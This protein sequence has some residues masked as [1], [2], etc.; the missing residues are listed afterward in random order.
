MSAANMF[1]RCCFFLALPET[2]LRGWEQYAHGFGAVSDQCAKFDATPLSAEVTQAMPPSVCCPGTDSENEWFLEWDKWTMVHRWIEDY[3]LLE[4]MSFYVF[5]VT[6]H[7]VMLSQ[8]PCWSLVSAC[9]P[10]DSGLVKL[11]AACVAMPCRDWWFF[12][13]P[14]FSQYM[15]GLGPHLWVR[16][17]AL[18]AA[19]HVPRVALSSLCRFESDLVNLVYSAKVDYGSQLAKDTSIR[20]SGLLG[21]IFVEGKQAAKSSEGKFLLRFCH[22]YPSQV[23]LGIRG[24]QVAAAS[25]L[26]AFDGIFWHVVCRQPQSAAAFE[27][28]ERWMSFIVAL[29][30][31]FLFLEGMIEFMRALVEVWQHAAAAFQALNRFFTLV[32]DYCGELK[33]VKEAQRP[34]YASQAEATPRVD[35]GEVSQAPGENAARSFKDKNSCTK[36]R[37]N[38]ECFFVIDLSGKTLTMTSSLDSYVS[39][40]VRDVSSVT[41]IPVEKFYLVVEG[42]VL[43]LDLTLHQA[44]I[45]RDVSVRMCFRL[46][47][48]VRHEVPGSWTC[49]VCNMGG[50]WPVRQNCFRCGAVR[51]SGP[52][53]PSGREMRYPGRG[54][55]GRASNGNPTSRQPRPKPHPVGQQPSS[56]LNTPQHSSL[57]LDASTLLQVLQSLGLGQDL[58]TQVEAKLSPPPKKERGPEKRLTTLKGKIHMCQQQLVKLRKQC[59]NT[60][61]TFLELEQKFIAKEK[62]QHEYSQEYTEILRNKKLTPTP[63]EKGAED[64]LVE[65]LQEDADEELT[66]VDESK[67]TVEKGSPPP[68]P[69]LTQG[70][71]ALGLERTKAITAGEQ[72]QFLEVRRLGSSRFSPYEAKRLRLWKNRERWV[73]MGSDDEDIIHTSNYFAALENESSGSGQLMNQDG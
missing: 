38:K 8:F 27:V 17:L 72:P 46:N 2:V 15:E 57:K 61:K 39:S 6:F 47:G 36:G 68:E 69:V 33:F 43:S 16:G 48:G 23:M 18:R 19:T 20:E 30:F 4:K 25:T 5:H 22:N 63:S 59:D 35:V 60:V 10:L 7:D 14:V 49:M 3:L 73:D 11:R 64:T 31:A 28:A 42:R 67:V 1:S 52:H 50:C 70:R 58:L 37:L 32:V 21:L 44:G 65:P 29:V 62:E 71:S 41:G 40:L 45:S 34:H 9:A 54:V 26:A 13:A 51:G 12:I 24:I 56:S 53:V 66:P 55:G